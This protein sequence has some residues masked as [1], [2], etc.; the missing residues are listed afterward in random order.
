[1]YYQMSLKL[2][3]TVNDQEN[4]LSFEQITLMDQTICTR[5]QLRFQVFKNCRSKIGM[6]TTANKIYYLN[7]LISFDMLN[8]GF[9]H[10]KKLSKIQFL[11]NGST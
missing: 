5:R 9:V 7:N 8:L 11:K 2:Y 1:M 4:E 6:N 3:K 10:F